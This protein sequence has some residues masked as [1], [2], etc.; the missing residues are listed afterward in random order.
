MWTYY[1]MHQ[2]F[3][4]VLWKQSVDPISKDVNIIILKKNEGSPI[5]AGNFAT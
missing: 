1:L 2:K 4:F 5:A 3:T